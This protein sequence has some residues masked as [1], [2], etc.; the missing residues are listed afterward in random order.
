ML[1]LNLQKINRKH[2][3]EYA[4]SFSNENELMGRHITNPKVQQV[5]TLDIY[6]RTSHPLAS[7]ME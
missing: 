2:C 4:L 5:F 3:S 6:R 7:W 1:S